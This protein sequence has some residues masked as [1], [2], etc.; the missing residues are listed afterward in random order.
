MLVLTN[1]HPDVTENVLRD[2]LLG[3]GEVTS[4]LVN[5]PQDG[6]QGYALVEMD[7]DIDAARIVREMN[8]EEIFGQVVSISREL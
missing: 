4:I 5:P 2:F 3:M 7:L 1:L 8:H 6:Q